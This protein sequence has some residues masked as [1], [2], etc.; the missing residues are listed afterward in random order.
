MDCSSWSSL[1]RKKKRTRRDGDTIQPFSKIASEIRHGD[2][3]WDHPY[4]LDL[5]LAGQLELLLIHEE[6]ICSDVEHLMG[7]LVFRCPSQHHFDDHSHI[8]QAR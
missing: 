7:I 8:D 2:D 4:F 3:Q 5:S 6:R 1:C